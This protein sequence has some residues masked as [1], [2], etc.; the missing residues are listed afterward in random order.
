[1]FNLF[2]LGKK[3]TEFGSWLDR[4]GISQIELEEKSQL[5]HGT[6]S[7]L[8]NDKKYK[9]KHSTLAKLRR[10]LKALG[11]DVPDDYFKM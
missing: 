10:G 8:C 3:R 1:M 11:K 5:S 7:K 6:I 4:E 9:P 2:G